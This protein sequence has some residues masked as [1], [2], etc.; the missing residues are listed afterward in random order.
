MLQAVR[1]SRSGEVEEAVQEKEEA[2]EDACE[3]LFC[4]RSAIIGH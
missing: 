2:H 1:L 4:A 3:A